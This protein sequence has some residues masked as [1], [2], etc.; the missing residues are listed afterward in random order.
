VTSLRALALGPAFSLLLTISPCAAQ[1][2]PNTAETPPAIQFSV[3]DQPPA[4]A[5][6]ATP[7]PEQPAQPEMAAPDPSPIPPPAAAEVP[8]PPAQTPP[9]T[10][11]APSPPA[12]T[13]PATTEAPSPP[14]QTPPA[15][16]EAPS[17]FAQTP[18]T[19]AEAPSPPAPAPSP[20]AEAPLPPPVVPA[21][22]APAP[23]PPPP[24]DPK[25]VKLQIASAGGAYMKSQELAYF[26]PFS[27]RT[28]YSVSSMAFDGAL[29]SLKGQGA[30]PKW[31]LV[32]LDQDVAAQ[33]CQEG[34]LEPIDAAIVQPGPDGATPAEDFLPG[35]IQSCSVASTAWSAV[36]VY[37][38][39]L[40]AVP[41]K[42][43]HFLDVKKFPGKRALPR[44]PQHTL[45]LMLLADGVAPDEVYAK[46]AT[47]EGQDR[48]FSRLS[49]IKDQIVWWDRAADAIDKIARKQVAMG[50]AFNGRAF[51]AMVQGRQPIAVLWHRAIYHLNVW[52][53]PKGAKFAGP[54][55]EFIG[56]ATS[57]GPL[58]D[59]TRWMPYGP[60]RLSAVK[61]AGKHAELNLDMKPYL[62]TY[63]A[64]LQGAL[65]FSGAWW[66]QQQPLKDRFAA[67][68]EGREL[69][70][71]STSQ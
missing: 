56:F 9:A 70:E 7:A 22:T 38:K 57:A 19:T 20:P 58:A 66:A 62:P 5:P 50:L 46:L 30:A 51:M 52:A 6:N 14:A 37:D 39:N 69:P 42:A 12:Q 23:P 48:A 27:K 11:E 13:P 35:S 24:L 55:R 60:A 2:P 49:A 68:L 8:S 21:I 33:A 26:R 71:A 53:I 43:E 47:K 25:D 17:P 67:W 36:I 3:P 59:Q 15:T 40:K 28:G 10:V 45:E 65:A 54:A 64:N 44:T 32:D 34:L 4:A 63:Q 29:A 41:T 1:T 18:P 16:V 61:L 31:D